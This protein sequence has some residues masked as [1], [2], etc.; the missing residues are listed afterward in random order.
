MHRNAPLT[1]EGRLRL[2]HRIET[3]W[4]RAAAAESMNIS[5]QTAHKWWSRYRYEGTE[6]LADR[7]SRPH[8][9]EV[10]PGN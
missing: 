9:S 6:G 7:S 2:C 4:S 1:P 3:G 10:T 8:R 5:R